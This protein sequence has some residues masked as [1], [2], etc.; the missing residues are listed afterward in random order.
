MKEKT[1]SQ[2]NFELK[3][4]DMGKNN[5]PRKFWNKAERYERK[6]YFTCKF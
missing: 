3:S 1:I 4:L 6:N 5:F 2:V